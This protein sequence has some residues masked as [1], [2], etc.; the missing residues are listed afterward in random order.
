MDFVIF[1]VIGRLPMPELQKSGIELLGDVSW[2]THFCVFY[3]TK[4][5]LLEILVPYFK[6]GLENNEF[7][8]WIVSDPVTCEDAINGLRAVCDF[9][10]YDAEKRIE[11]VGS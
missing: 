5:D 10:R 1:N 3:E 2:G 6:A 7:C 8:L 4:K 11:I 9:D